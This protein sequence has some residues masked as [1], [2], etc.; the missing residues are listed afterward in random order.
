MPSART[1]ANSS[2]RCTAFTA[3]STSSSDEMTS[4]AA[5]TVLS[6]PGNSGTAVAA[7]RPLAVVTVPCVSCPVRT[8]SSSMG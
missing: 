2:W 1:V 6:S 3:L 8:A 4:T 7:T 5:T